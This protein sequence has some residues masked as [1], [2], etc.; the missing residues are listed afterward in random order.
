MLDVFFVVFFQYVCQCAA[1]ACLHANHLDVWQGGALAGV[2]Q[3]QDFFLGQ[4]GEDAKR[5]EE[6]LGRQNVD[7]ANVMDLAGFAF[8]VSYDPLKLELD[9]QNH[10][11]YQFSI[12]NPLNQPHHLNISLVLDFHPS[13]R[14]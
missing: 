12:L 8:T 9:R 13:L 10:T 1:D 11:S 3:F 2:D 14:I 4:K 6:P 5:I 7:V